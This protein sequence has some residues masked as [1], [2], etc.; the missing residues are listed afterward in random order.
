VKF[1]SG[2]GD[3]KKRLGARFAA[4]AAALAISASGAGCGIGSSVTD[5]AGYQPPFLPVIITIDSAG[6]ISIHGK[7]SVVTP[8]GTF[9]LE[10]NISKALAPVADTTL[11]VIKHRQ[12]ISV[13]YSAFR[14]KS[15]QV[16]VS[17]NGHVRLNVTAD[18]VF[19]NAVRARVQSIV[20][21]SASA[22]SSRLNA[23]LVGTWRDGEGRNSTTWDG[24]V[25]TMYGGAGNVDYIFAT[26]IDQ[27]SWGSS[28]PLYGMYQGHRLKEIIRGDN[29]LS[30]VK[31]VR[32]NELQV[33]ED[34]WSTDSANTFTYKS[35][36]SLGYFNKSGT[37]AN[38][39]R[40]T[41][42]QL[43]WRVNG[44]VNTET[45]ISRQP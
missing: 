45:R 20:I 37:S 35:H 10:A 11:L 32:S 40:C 34:G 16:D 14:V 39:F 13:V 12:G 33:V 36:T 25:V 29:T 6:N 3:N 21:R 18:R 5:S 44:I 42:R 38:Y 19:V 9:F 1:L 7:L 28:K 8:A 22:G 23:C 27:D 43:T 24:H 4:V 2:H 15:Q 31:T 41:S 26:G 17:L 30:L